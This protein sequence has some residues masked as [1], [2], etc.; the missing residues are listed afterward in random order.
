MNTFQMLAPA[1]LS[2]AQT[3]VF[4]DG[5]QALIDGNGHVNV[6]QQ[7]LVD[8]LAQGFTIVTPD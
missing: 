2:A 6:P 4:K 3:V 1:R 5:S 8:M 7:F